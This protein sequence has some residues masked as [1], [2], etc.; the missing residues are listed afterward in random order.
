MYKTVQNQYLLRLIL[1]ISTW[2]IWE[3]ESE[4]AEK[5]EKTSLT[6]SKQP[7]PDGRGNRNPHYH[8]KYM[9]YLRSTILFCNSKIQK[10]LKTQFDAK[11]ILMAKVDL[12]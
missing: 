6:D 3:T 10:A 1:L 11:T 5:Y 4:I 8:T 2:L 9:I 7:E 12:N